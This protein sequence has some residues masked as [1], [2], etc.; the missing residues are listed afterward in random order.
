MYARENRLEASVRLKRDVKDG[1]LDLTVKAEAGPVVNLVYEGIDVKASV[2][3][4]VREIW[5]SGVFDEQRA[6]ESIDVIR[7]WLVSQNHLQPKIDYKIAESQ[8]DQKR[9]VF[10]IQPGPKFTKVELAFDGAKGVTE[11]TLRKIV[12]Q[13]KLS[14]D[15]YV[16]PGRVTELLTKYYQEERVLDAKVENRAMNSTR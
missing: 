8:P 4:R 10:D 15:V 14:S 12:K 2:Q 11:D 9:V 5:Q 1:G 6:E 13:Q 3:K 16:K 7:G